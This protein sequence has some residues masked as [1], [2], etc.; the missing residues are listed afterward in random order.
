M[1][2][3]HL[4]RMANEI[5]E[6]FETATEPDNIAD[7][8]RG[9]LLRYWAPSMRAALKDHLAGHP[10]DSGLNPHV[11]AAVANLRDEPAGN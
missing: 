6:F 1:D 3:E 4:V 7:E 9:H 11:A 8:V 5:G 2:S 10:A